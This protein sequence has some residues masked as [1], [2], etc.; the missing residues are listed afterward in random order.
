MARILV[1]EDNPANMKLASLLLTN[2]GHTVLC[3]VDAECGLVIARTDQPDLILMDIQLPGMDGLAATALLKKD[4][5]TVAI[6]VIALTAMAMKDDQEKTRVAGCDAYIAKPLRYQEFYRV[7]NL[8]LFKASSSTTSKSD[9]TH[10]V[11]CQPL[12]CDTDLKP[13]AY[14][15]VVQSEHIILVAEDNM[16][17]Q[18]LILRQLSLLGFVA[19]VVGDGRLAFEL[20]Q[21]GHYAL[22]LTDLH[23]PELDGYAL[24]AAV[25][26]QERGLRRIPIIALTA[27]AK[28]DEADQCRAAGMDAYLCKPLKLSALK[29]MLDTWLPTAD[30]GKQWQA[31]SE[32]VLVSKLVVDQSV[33]ENLVGKDPLIIRE[34]QSDFQVSAGKIA[35]ELI[36][37][38]VDG[39]VSTAGDLAHKLRASA[40]AV[41]ARILGDLCVQMEAAGKAGDTKKLMG[42]LPLFERELQA[43]MMFLDSLLVLYGDQHHDKFKNDDSRIK[44]L[45]LDDESFMHK[46]LA[47]MLS[48]LGY[49][50]VVTCESGLAAL[51]LVDAYSNAPNLILMD[52]NMP[53]MDGI[54][55]VR[56]LVEHNY[57][58]SLVLISGEDERVLQ[59]AEKLVQAHHITVLGHLKKP[60]SLDGLASMV[61]KWRP[62][63]M[64]QQAS[65][66]YRADELKNAIDTDMLVNFYQPK[67][68]LATGA[69]IGVETL[70]RWRHPIDGLVLPDM[71][72]GLAEDHGLIDDLTRVI[73][74]NAL[75]QIRQWQQEGLNLRVAVNV[76]M[77]NLISVNFADFVAATASA[78][79]VAPS[80]ILLEVTESRLMMDHRMPLEVLTRLRL[81]RFGLSIDDFG[82]GHSSLTQLHD[83][84]FNE[85]KIDR[86]FVHGA[87]HDET[88]LAMYN[89]SLGL[90][91]Q[92]GM[93]V[94]AEGVEDR[95]DWEFLRRTECDQAQGY[96]IARPMPAEELPGW[97]A[98]WSKRTHEL[99]KP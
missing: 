59:A 66:N 62:A 85:L 65:K 99:C 29:L 23:M 35:V 38:C 28:H 12:K 74:T 39:D 93:Q 15:A 72:I 54:E 2:V 96:F 47:H 52:L 94:V 48:G 49:N 45:I 6:P 43:V 76:S 61:N 37:A 68:V 11:A 19:D 3:A 87:W 50:S 98:S 22:L 55:F 70:A 95:E 77:D 18:K 41:G 30:S 10:S 26:T 16:L 57:K 44:I 17:N 88:V 86:S 81:K 80:D 27:T 79:G 5:V 1:I 9:F 90:G 7:I 13:L 14:D 51:D 34:F 42:L 24:T 69:V 84:P 25:R 32:T 63:R 75:K 89:A 36:A 46:L 97:I 40:H 60:V 4:P 92:L 64:H 67:V 58:G 53:E 20:W 82:T 91:K 33:L 71:F 56:M 21:S 78:A 73:L 31:E 8:L 83:I